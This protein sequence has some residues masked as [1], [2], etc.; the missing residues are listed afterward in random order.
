MKKIVLSL[1]I[2]FFAINSMSLSSVKANDLKSNI[3]QEFEILQDKIDLAL[4]INNGKYIYDADEIKQI[5]ENYDL[6][7]SELSKHL[8]V[9]LTKESFLEQTLS[10]LKSTDTTIVYEDSSCSITT[11]GTYCGRNAS[12]SGWNYTRKF[13]D[14]AKSEVAS[15]KFLDIYYKNMNDYQFNAIHAIQ[16]HLPSWAAIGIGLG[17]AGAAY[18]TVYSLKLSTEIHHAN[19][20]RCGTVVD[21]NIFTKQI[22]AW[23]QDT[24]YV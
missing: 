19:K 13:T 10:R 11:R 6:D 4:E 9:E 14:K 16:E 18:E 24:F 17:S 21:V 2:S 3:I 22:S 12:A 20:G 8:D 5:I 23:S 15:T 1:L 7:F